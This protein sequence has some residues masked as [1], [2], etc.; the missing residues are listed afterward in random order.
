MNNDERPEDEKHR[1]SITLMWF[2]LLGVLLYKYHG[3]PYRSNL[4]PTAGKIALGTIVSVICIGWWRR[5]R[6]LK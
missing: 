4:N 2:V 6:S 3:Q 1:V 5:N